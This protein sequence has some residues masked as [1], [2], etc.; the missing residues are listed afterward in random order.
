VKRTPFPGGWIDLLPL[1][2]QRVGSLV[3]QVIGWLAIGALVLK[4]CWPSLF[5]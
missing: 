5:D 1:W 3:L 4:V 2:L